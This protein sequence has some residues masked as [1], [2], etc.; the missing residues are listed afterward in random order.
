MRLLSYL[1]GIIR[2]TRDWSTASIVVVPRSPRFRFVV[3]LVK[4]CDMYAL[5]R[6]TLP[7]AVLLKRFAAPR[8]V[9]SFGIVVFR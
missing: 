5:L 7:D 4:M 8:C 9:F 3:L 6:V 2:D 1:Y